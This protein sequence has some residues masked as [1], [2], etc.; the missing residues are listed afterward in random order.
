MTIQEI[1]QKLERKVLQLA[2]QANQLNF[3]AFLTSP[4]KSG[5]YINYPGDSDE[6][7]E[8]LEN[9][10]DIVENKIALADEAYFILKN[11]WDQIA[12]SKQEAAR[13]NM[14]KIQEL[15]N[16]LRRL[17]DLYES[18]I[19]EPGVILI[20]DGEREDPESFHIEIDPPTSL[21]KK[22]AEEV[23]KNWKSLLIQ[24]EAAVATELN[25]DLS[26]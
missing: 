24:V 26:L 7:E 14:A 22:Q 13:A 19:V 25:L 9:N 4:K 6:M 5:S 12:E 3:S 20:E 2:P 1:N 16:N 10:L 21:S 15:A 11:N 18:L 8:I 17:K 23:T